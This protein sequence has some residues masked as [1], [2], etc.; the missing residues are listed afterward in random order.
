MW[1]VLSGV[2]VGMVSEPMSQVTVLLLGGLWIE[3][4]SVTF[5][6]FWAEYCP[7]G[8]TCMAA[9]DSYPLLD[10]GR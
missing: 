6:L 7:E 4:R 8:P 5:G 9:G 3:G 10:R 1:G 2:P